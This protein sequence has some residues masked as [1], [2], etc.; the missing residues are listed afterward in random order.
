MDK[1]D[2]IHVQLLL[3]LMDKNPDYQFETIEICEHIV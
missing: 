1:F 2:N 3:Q